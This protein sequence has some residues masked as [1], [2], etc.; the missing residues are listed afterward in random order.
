[1]TTYVG[2]SR[3]A[4]SAVLDDEQLE[5]LRVPAGQRVDWEADTINP[6]PDPP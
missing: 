6:L 5:A 2:G 1:M 4:I 3:E